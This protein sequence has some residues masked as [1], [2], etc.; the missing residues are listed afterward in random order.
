MTATDQTKTEQ[1]GSAATSARPDYA[2]LI[3]GFLTS[4]GEPIRATSDAVAR[5][6]ALP[7]PTQSSAAVLNEADRQIARL[8]S[9]RG[10]GP[11][12]AGLYSK[13]PNA[14]SLDA[15]IALIKKLRYFPLPIPMASVGSHGNAGLYWSDDRLY[16]DIELLEDGR[17]GYLLQPVGD[18]V[19]DS[20]D[21]IPT[22]GL[23]SDIARALA[24]AYLFGKG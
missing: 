17:I 11:G 12:W 24:A 18:R 10:A 2:A 13:A 8:N 15:A 22:I 20:E 6:V 3:S 4:F 19:I 5:A 14:R 16:A 9:M 23:P 7:P 1:S 21:D